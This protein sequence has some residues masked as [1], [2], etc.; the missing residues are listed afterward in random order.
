MKGDFSRETFD[1][2]KHFNAVLMQQ[3]RVQV[4]A[5][6]NEQQAI[7]QHRTET[8]AID[9]IGKCGAPKHHAG[10]G[11]TATGA[12]FTISAGRFYVD[13]LLCENEAEAL[14][15]EQP[16][17][18]N[19]PGL[20]EW[21]A[22]GASFGIIYLDVWKRHL[23][24]LEDPSIREVALDGP[25]T[26]TRVKTIW[27]VKVLPVVESVNE[28]TCETELEAWNDLISPVTGTLTA[29]TTIAEDPESPCLIPPD[30]GY[31]RLENQ[32]YRVE[33]HQDSEAVG[34]A[35]YK[36]SRDNGAIVTEILA[37]SGA[38]ITVA[39]LG[40]DDVLGFAKG[41]WVEIL[42][43]TLE[44]RGDPGEL[45][46]IQDFATDANGRSVIVLASA[47]TQLASDPDFP[48]ADRHPK[49]RRWDGAAT[50]GLPVATTLT[51]LEGGI[52]VQFSNDTYA[53]GNYWLIPARTATGQIEWPATDDGTLT[54][55]PQLP[56]GITH[57]Y[58]RLAIA[59]FI[60]SNPN[61]DETESISI[62]QNCDHSFCPLT[63]LDPGEGCCTVVVQPGE[64]IQAALDALPSGG[65]CVCLKTGIHEI[66]APLRI[67]KSNVVLKGESPGTQV[68]RNNG[69]N[70]LV[71]AEPQNQLLT[72]IVVEQIRFTAAGRDTAAPS[73]LGVIAL[74]I[75]NCADT[76]VQHCHI[77]IAELPR[78]VGAGSTLPIASA[79]GIAIVNARQIAIVENTLRL[80]AI[81]VWAENCSAS[82]FSANQLFGPVIQLTDRLAVSLGYISFLLNLLP[83]DVSLLGADCWVE[84]NSLQDYLLG[85]VAGERCDRCQIVNNQVRRQAVTQLPIQEFNNQ[86]LAGSE[87]YIYGIIT[88]SDHCT[89]AGNYLDL[90]S[91]SYGGIRVFGSHTRIQD[92]IL[93]STL[94]RELQVGS[95]QLPLAIF[96]GNIQATDNQPSVFAANAGVVRDNQLRGILTGI[97]AANVEAVEIVANQLEFSPSFAP[98]TAAGI[99]LGNSRYTYVANNQ[100]RNAELGIFLLSDPPTGGMGNRILENYVSDSN[101]GISAVAETDLE[102]SGN[103]IEDARLAGF[104]A[105]NLVATAKLSQNRIDHCGYQPPISAGNNAGIGAGIF[106]VAVLGNLTIDSCQVMNTGISSQ[107]QVAANTALWGMAIGAV[108]ACQITHNQVYYSDIANL[109]AINV[110]QAHRSLLLLGWFFPANPEI[111]FPQLG[112][113]LV[114]NNVFQG[115]GSPHLVEFLRNP[116]VPQFGFAQLNFSHN[117]CFH[118]LAGGIR[119]QIITVS[120]WGRQLAVMGN[121]ITAN[122]PQFISLNLN[123]AQRITLMGNIASGEIVNFGSGISPANSGDFNIYP[124]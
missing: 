50:N 99:A 17:W 27:Q 83:S 66:R 16:D 79:I 85:I 29:Q 37:V 38:E 74:L 53:T 59:Q 98:L 34:G 40:P 118:L 5:D 77:E 71:I 67:A 43:D 107:G 72:D 62:L 41:Q 28:L 76:R 95:T 2:T 19:P 88:Y 70:L 96:L 80:A 89:I 44:L 112:S 18:P 46:E 55:L 3:G 86:F 47:P 21:L 75:S 117:Q 82:R 115:L 49:L 124:S 102:V 94:N 64:D 35:T 120:A 52:Q 116:D 58:C 45:I 8:E 23:T 31:R 25:D 60:P 101:Y 104:A 1:R 68:I 123:A 81:G 105:L 87:P 51:E 92:N 48:N 110:D 113:A 4:D 30:A 122:N 9:V 106:I 15:S 42:D 24:A 78:D 90:G 26:T 65:G 114:T 11:I 22:T 33:I 13:G 97:G 121:Q 12:D 61:N 20:D 93:Q 32:L 10:F 100:I 57:H 7:R 36:W 39:D 56:L 91:P 54:P 109:S 103:L 73:L 84:E 63:E 14:Y 69:L 108:T 119:R 111:R 6:W